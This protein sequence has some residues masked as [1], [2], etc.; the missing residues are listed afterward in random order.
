M[1]E[2]IIV[3]GIVIL[4]QV[5]TPPQETGITV[6]HLPG[7][8]LLGTGLDVVAYILVKYDIALEL[9]VAL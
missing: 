5:G 2:P 1:E 6:H 8:G 7:F 9:I 3:V 4:Q